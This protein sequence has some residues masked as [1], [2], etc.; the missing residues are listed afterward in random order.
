MHCPILLYKSNYWTFVHAFVMFMNH[1][2][3]IF[4]NSVDRAARDRAPFRGSVPPR[5]GSFDIPGCSLFPVEQRLGG[6]ELRRQVDAGVLAGHDDGCTDVHIGH[7]LHGGKLAIEALEPVFLV[8]IVDGETALPHQRDL[9]GDLF[10]KLQFVFEEPERGEAVHDHI[11][12]ECT[13]GGLAHDFFSD[14]GKQLFALLGYLGLG[15]KL[16]RPLQDNVGFG[17][18]A[19]DFQGVAVIVESKLI[20]REHFEGDAE[21]LQRLVDVG[22]GEHTAKVAVG[23]AVVGVDFQGI[24]KSR[25]RTG[26][27]THTAERNAQ[28]CPTEGIGRSQF[29]VPPQ[30]KNGFIKP[31][32]IAERHAEVVEDGSVVRL[33]TKHGLKNRNSKV[34]VALL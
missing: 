28:S 17:N 25:N 8:R 6:L 1:E 10:A 23:V 29:R 24:A 13:T 20:V 4:V 22:I 34:N 27:V 5:R 19:R 7:K 33:N 3:H 11:H 21:V 32:L 18:V 2:H 26:L 16:D 14:G 12:A 9:E 15:I 30:N 31:V